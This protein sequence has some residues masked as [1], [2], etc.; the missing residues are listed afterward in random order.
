MDSKLLTS[1]MRIKSD[2]HLKSEAV[3]CTESV[4]ATAPALACLNFL[5]AFLYSLEPCPGVDHLII[6]LA[7]GSPYRLS[8]SDLLVLRSIS[9]H[10][11]GFTRIRLRFLIA[12]GFHGIGYDS[13]FGLDE[14]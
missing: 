12:R 5:I 9:Q 7:L 8:T 14:A 6:A 13:V 1:E 4:L 3:A 10:A 2:S 11:R